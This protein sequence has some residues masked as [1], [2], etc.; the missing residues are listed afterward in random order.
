MRSSLCITVIYLAVQL[1]GAAI[2]QPISS[3]ETEEALTGF[4]PGGIT[5][6]RVREHASDGEWALKAF[7]PG[8]ES[9]T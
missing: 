8:N 6:E 1:S 4:S 5:L 7:F 3:F 2:S 9:D